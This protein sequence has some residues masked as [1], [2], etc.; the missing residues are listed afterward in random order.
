MY[1]RALEW[2]PYLGE[3]Y[4]ELGRVLQS[5]GIYNLAQENLEK[6]MYKFKVAFEKDYDD[7]IE[8]K[9]LEVLKNKGL[10]NEK[11]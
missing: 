2:D 4:Y 7:I 3:V 9:V 6:A 5:R 10:L 1:E 11:E 8:Q